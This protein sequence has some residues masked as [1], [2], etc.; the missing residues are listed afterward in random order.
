[1][2]K[3]FKWTTKKGDFYLAEHDGRWHVVFDEMSLGAYVNTSQ[4][5]DDLV[6]GHTFSAGK[7]IDTSKLGIG[8]DLGEWERVI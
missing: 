5:I 1:M 3:R 7:G 8:D 2:R 6:G 4:A